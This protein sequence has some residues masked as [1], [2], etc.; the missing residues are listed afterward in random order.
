[1]V[2]LSHKLRQVKNNANPQLNANVGGSDTT[3]A[4]KS[5][6]GARL[7]S[8]LTGTASSTGDGRVLNDTGD[9]GSVAVGDFIE[10]VTDGSVAVVTVAGTNSITTTPLFGGSDNTWTS[11]DTWAVGRFVCTLAQVDADGAITQSERILVTNRTTD[12]LTVTRG[13]GSDTQYSFV[14]DDYCF[15]LVEQS[16]T[17]EIKKGL[18]HFHIKMQEAY[19]YKHGYAAATGS[20]NAFAITLTPAVAAMADI[21]GMPIVFKANHSVTG[22]STLNVNGLGATSIKRKNDI[23]IAT[24]DIENS[25]MVT[26]IY[27]GTNFQ[28]QNEKASADASGA[29]NIMLVPRAGFPSNVFSCAAAAKSLGGSDLAFDATTTGTS[30][31]ASSHTISHTCT[32]SNRLLVVGFSLQGSTS[33]L[34]TNVTYNG[35]AMTQVCNSST[36]LDFSAR[37]YLYTLIAPASGANNVV[38]TLSSSSTVNYSFL[39]YTGAAQ[40]GQPTSGDVNAPAGAATSITTTST[41]ING[42]GWLAGYA[43]NDVGNYAAGTST[44]IRNAASAVMGCDSNGVDTQSLTLTSA[45]ARHALAVVPVKAANVYPS[46]E[47]FDFD[48]NNEESAEWEVVM[49]ST[50]TGGT[51]T[52][53]FHWTTSVASGNVVWGCQAICVGDNETMKTA[54][55]TAQT[56]TDGSNGTDKMNLSA[57]TSAIT[58]AGTPAAS[59]TVV[60]RV[61]RDATNASD[62]LAGDAR[63]VA[64]EINF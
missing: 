27:D 35:V 30:A 44:T 37:I 20:S 4:L 28:M 24:G 60:F 19:E 11:G 41:K 18:R 50:Y 33:D 10:N 46:E 9:L 7:P 53:K 63:L 31:Y 43:R 8:I 38:I 12:T 13:F 57:A 29:T 16:E 61:Y 14:A 22:A 49:P 39:S 54:F 45:S 1:M 5:G 64:V 58:I 59:K 17:D 23:A 25:Q 42:I 51:V 52:V 21:V 56:V 36:S 3:I 32:G 55:G 26:V 2:N 6:H 34:V 47:T 40:S 48:Q 15:L 62:T